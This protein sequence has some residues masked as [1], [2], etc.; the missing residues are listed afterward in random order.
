MTS[1]PPHSDADAPSRWLERP[2]RLI[3]RLRPRTLAELG[4]IATLFVVAAGL[5]GFVAIAEEIV[6]GETHA[7]D[8]TILRALRSATDPGDPIGPAWL[9]IVFRDLT[10][11]GSITVLTVVTLVVLGYLLIDGKRSAALFVLVSVAGGALLVDAVKLFIARPRPDLVAHLVQVQTYSF[12][13][14]HATASAVTFLTLGTLLGRV[15]GRKR[16]KAYVLGTAMAL[17]LLV[18]ASR[19]YLGVHWPSDVLAGWSLGAAWAMLCWQVGLWLQS[20][21]RIE[22]PRPD[23][24]SA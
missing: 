1:S 17:T 19:V 14:G 13:S 23:Q 12:P 15:L 24:D 16:L 6:E 9:E 4:P 7:F 2:L 20:R 8:E 18:G 5:L 10:A 21:G 11:L 22:T 3:R